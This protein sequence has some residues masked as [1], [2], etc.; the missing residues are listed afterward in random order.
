MEPKCSD[1][2]QP[3]VFLD[4]FKGHRASDFA[5][6]VLAAERYLDGDGLPLPAVSLAHLMILE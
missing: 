4:N 2:G 5:I 1:F 3:D 6:V